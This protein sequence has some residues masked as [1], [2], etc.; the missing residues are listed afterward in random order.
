HPGGDVL[1][2][3]ASLGATSSFGTRAGRRGPP[4]FLRDRTRKRRPPGA[5]GFAHLP[6][7]RI[8][9]VFPRDRRSARVAVDAGAVRIENGGRVLWHVAPGPGGVDAGFR[10]R[11]PRADVPRA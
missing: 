11:R 2:P 10:R 9:M 1:D 3:G 8:P 6:L 5:G 4:P 7:N